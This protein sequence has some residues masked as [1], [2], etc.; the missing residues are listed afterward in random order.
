MVYDHTCQF[1]AIQPVTQWAHRDGD[2]WQTIFT[3]SQR[4]PS[5]WIFLAPLMHQR[6]VASKN[7]GRSSYQPSNA[8][9]GNPCIISS[10]PVHPK[11]PRNLES[12]GSGT[13]RNVGFQNV[14]IRIDA[15]SGNTH[16]YSNHKYIYCPGINSQHQ[17]LTIP[18]LMDVPYCSHWW[19]AQKTS[20]HDLCTVDYYEHIN[21]VL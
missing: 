15:C 21:C 4:N 2:L 9:M 20:W 11:T 13:M 6:S 10:R 3:H 1:A 8:I 12:T 18:L 7:A 16:L 5:T 19:R 17:G 14:D